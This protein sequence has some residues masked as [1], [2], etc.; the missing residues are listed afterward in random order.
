MKV[1]EHI[2]KA[3]GKTQF[4]FEI[5][6][7][8]KGQNI[9]C[10]FDGIDPLMEFNPPF[11]D[12]TYHREEYEYKELGN[13]LL[14]KKIVKKRPG[15][16]GICAGI[17]NKYNVDAIPHILCGGFTKE[18]TENLLID[19]DFLGIDN[20]VA[21]R[22][23]AVKS[24]IYFKPE[25][26]GNEYAS[27]LVKQISD[28]NNGKYLDADLQNTNATDFC[29]GVAG[30]PEKHMEAPSLDSDI[31]F[32]KQKIANGA[33][34]IITQMFFDNKKFFDFVSKCRKAGINVPIIPGLKPIATKKQLNLIPHRFSLELPD[35]LIMAVVKA[36][37]NEAVKQ[38]GIEWCI[39][40]S[41][42]LVKAGIPVLHYYSMGKAENIKA[43]AKEV[44]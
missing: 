25:K 24:E 5:L 34:Y 29:I 15:T 23:D 6:P 3:S 1:T 41:K 36:K 20:V 4:S 33:D 10:I 31:H 38:I 7:P 22:G 39:A 12:V 26:E 21:L 27:E 16:V 30:Y 35:D 9:Q 28:L 18:D 13:G 8:L 37:D 43:I 32:L 44:F 40:Q 19:L 14:Q 17:Q 2:A 42:E 11:I